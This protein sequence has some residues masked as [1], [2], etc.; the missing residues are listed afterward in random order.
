M[1]PRQVNA[2]LSVI[3]EEDPSDTFGAN[4]KEILEYFSKPDPCLLGP[5]NYDAISDF[6][7]L[8][9]KIAKV[10]R[11]ALITDDVGA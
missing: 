1:N 4:D 6:L 11:T 2:P 8:L 3:E 7:E 9:V 10:S 5:K